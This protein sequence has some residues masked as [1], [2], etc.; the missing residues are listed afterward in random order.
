MKTLLPYKYLLLLLPLALLSCGVSKDNSSSSRKPDWVAQRPTNTQYYIGIGYA[1]KLSNAADF[2]RVAK[3]NALDDMLGEIKVS[4]S[5]NSILSQYQN[6]QNFSQQFF[7]DTR[8]VASE[9]MEGFQV[10]D[11]WENKTEYWIYYRMNKADFEANKRRKLFE[12]I[13]KSLDLLYRADKLSLKT[14][15]VQAF[16]LR[17]KAAASLQNYLN[18]SIETEY[19]GK[20]VFLLNEILSQLQDQ[21]YLVQLKSEQQSLQAVAG[22]PIEQPIQV[23]ARV[24]TKDSLS[25]ALPYLPLKMEG[26]GI[27]FRG[28]IQTE[29]A[30]DGSAQ[31]AI[32]RIQSKD[33]LQ[34]LQIKTDIAKL[35]KGDSINPSMKNLLVNLEGPIANIRVKIE[36]IKI[37]MQATELNL[38]AK[39]N[40]PILTPALKKKLMEQ[41]CTFV[42]QINQA[43]YVLELT[44]NTQDQGIMWGQM[45]R[46]NLEMSLVLRDAHS[47]N[48]L[49]RDA[50][51]G[52]QGFQTTK[53]KAGIEAY[54]TMC[55]EMMNKMYPNLEHTLFN[56]D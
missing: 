19:Y 51:G 55:S 56:A 48:E 41:G 54:Q 45:L 26:N 49:Y 24:K 6:N 11:S 39:L 25:A 46:S 50:K 17:V 14:E 15:Y 37:Y 42:N 52:V 31:F 35:L 33:P 9:T 47:Q 4:V 27:L 22:K 53:E 29:T 43:D 13:E 18:E 16:K 2:Q 8:L 23:S 7:S 30:E 5:S 34:V 1:S 28:N 44:A 12:A 36:P 3:K 20:N 40:Y 38:D 21:L 10:M 32:G